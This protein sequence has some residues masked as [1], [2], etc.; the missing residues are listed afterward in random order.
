[1]SAA[2]CA[3]RKSGKLVSPPPAMDKERAVYRLERL[4]AG[5]LI[6]CMPGPTLQLIAPCLLQGVFVNPPPLSAAV[7]LGKPQQEEA[8]AKVSIREVEVTDSGIYGIHVT[9][10]YLDAIKCDVT[11]SRDSGV[12][13]K[14]GYVY[15]SGCTVSDNARFGV[16][17]SEKKD[18]EGRVVSTSAGEVKDCS[19]SG[20]TGVGVY[21]SGAECALVGTKVLQTKMSNPPVQAEGSGVSAVLGGLIS[22]SGCKIAQNAS[23]GIFV[24][25]GSE[26]LKRA[27]GVSVERSAVAHNGSYGASVA[28]ASP[29]TKGFRANLR[30]CARSDFSNNP[31]GPV[32]GFFYKDTALA[33]YV[34]AGLGV[35]ALAYLASRWKRQ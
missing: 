18:Q 6:L 1:M 12:V 14:G 25:G 23:F 29:D 5:L 22:L 32:E 26:S 9:G 27:S 17:Y 13:A 35:L 3:V 10:G 11:R 34:G 21:C 7:P 30:I 33:V 24:H 16:S 20:N 2:K 4:H 15:M 31:Q 8:R 19:V 28:P